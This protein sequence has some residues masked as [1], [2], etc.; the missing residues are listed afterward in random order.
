MEII[1]ITPQI[2]YIPSTTEPL[3]AE[4]V[5]I[6]GDAQTYIYDVG[7]REDVWSYL[8][9][10]GNTTII[11]S[12]FHGDH[13]DNIKNLFPNE[14]YVSKQTY[15][16]THFGKIVSDDIFIEDGELKLHIFLLPSS[17]S[18]GCLCLEV[19]NE[20]VFCG[21]A[22]YG[23]SY[24]NTEEVYNYQ[25]LQSEIETLKCIDAKYF[26]LSHRFNVR[27]T[28]KAVLSFLEKHLIK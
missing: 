26:F 8:Q 20:Y 27:Y 12:H 25:L 11:L 5:L 19:N 18:K 2:S 7:R 13:S 3:S 10:L 1:N 4:V 28:K 23:N 16:Y 21:D 15:K 14:L 24:K 17:H 22:I 9:N 6:K